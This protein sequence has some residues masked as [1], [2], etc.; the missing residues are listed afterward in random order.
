[1]TGLRELEKRLKEEPDNLGLRVTVAG[2]LREAGR[3]DEAVELYRSVAIAYRDQGRQQQAIAVCRSILEIAPDDI[4]CHAL[5]AALVAGHKGRASHDTAQVLAARTVA[6]EP[7]DP[8]APRRSS[9]DETPLPR[10]IP[11]H[12]ADPTTKSVKKQHADSEADL[13]AAEGV[14]TRPGSE[15][16]TKPEVTGMANA[17]RRISASLIASTDEDGLYDAVDLA[18]DL[19]AELETRQRPK[20]E[21]D[22]LLKISRPPPT[23]PVDRIDFDDAPTPSPVDAEARDRDTEEELTSPRELAEPTWTREPKTG[24]VGGTT[25]SVLE[26]AFF[27][28]LPPARREAVFSRFHRRA[29]AAGSTVIR[30]GE[31]EHSLVIVGRGRLEVKAERADGKLVLVTAIGPGE[32]VGEAA[33]L[34]RLPAPAH[35]IA[36][37]DSELLALQPRDFYEIAGAFPALWAEL[38]DLA[39]RRTRELQAKLKR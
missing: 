15:D 6:V 12:E 20:I 10:A 22:D 3:H 4:R 31:T 25:A 26:S 17:A 39:E 18:A 28:P 14:K 37:I 32:Y 38:K 24:P 2:A 9:Y 33:L 23:A 27:A 13:P 36:A 5:L 30:Q 7:A 21:S 35:V 1:M 11:Y 19:A 8:V 34:A 16:G 29:V